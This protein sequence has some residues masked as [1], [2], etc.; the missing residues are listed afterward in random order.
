ME[1]YLCGAGPPGRHGVTGRPIQA[2]HQALRDLK[3]KPSAKTGDRRT[4]GRAPSGSRRVVI[5]DGGIFSSSRSAVVF[6]RDV[7]LRSPIVPRHSRSCTRNVARPAPRVCSSRSTRPRQAGHGR[8]RDS[9]ADLNRAAVRDGAQ[10]CRRRSM[11]E[12][13]SAEGDVRRRWRAAGSA[14]EDL[15]RAVGIQS[16]RRR[17]VIGGR[18]SWLVKSS[19]RFKAIKRRGSWQW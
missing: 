2:A 7:H 10:G 14:Y 8:S 16:P 17:F 5:G 13:T 4:T 1:P 12:G 3:K 6:A 19:L 15:R 11:V 18:S 9:L